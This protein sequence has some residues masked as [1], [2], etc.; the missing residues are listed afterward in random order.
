M[1]TR[2]KHVSLTSHNKWLKHKFNLY[3]R[4]GVG[5]SEADKRKKTAIHGIFGA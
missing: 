1:Q 2:T 4:E 5:A 3:I